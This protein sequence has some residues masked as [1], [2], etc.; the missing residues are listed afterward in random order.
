MVDHEKSSGTSGPSPT[1]DE[2]SYAMEVNG[3]CVFPSV[4]PIEVCQQLRSDVFSHYERI[5]PL[6]IK[7]G[8]ADETEWGVHHPVGKRDA[9]HDFLQFDYLHSYISHYFDDKPYILSICGAPINPPASASGKYEHGHRWHRDIRTF[10]GHGKRQLLVML[11]MV[12]DFTI[13]NGATELI[14]GS[15]RVKDYPSERFIADNKRCLCG[16]CGSIVLIDGDLIH[17]A[18]NNKTDA[19]RLGLSC[20][21]SRASLKPVMDYSRFLSPEYAASLNPRMRQLFGFNARVP[22]NFDEWYQPVEKRFY[23]SDQG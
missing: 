18:G 2:F 15:H 3:Y 5:R 19:F 9:I 6:Q 14:P 4:V 12:D 17:R 7:A 8:L 22:S 10:V 20:V 1:N 21:F 16:L 13:E 11:L 23:R